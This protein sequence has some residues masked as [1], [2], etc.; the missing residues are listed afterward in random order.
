[1]EK[2]ISAQQRKNDTRE[3]VQD[4][5]QIPMQDLNLKA[6]EERIRIR[7]KVIR[8]QKRSIRADYRKRD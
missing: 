7:R 8:L 5:D 2:H 6:Q 1:M 4:I 3:E